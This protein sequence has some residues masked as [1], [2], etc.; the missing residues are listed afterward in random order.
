M[1]TPLNTNIDSLYD[2]VLQQMAAESYFE[3]IALTASAL[4]RERLILGANRENYRGGPSDLNDGYRGYTR[5]TSAQ[6][7]EFLRKF[8]IVHQWSDDPTPTGSRPAVEGRPDRPQ[9]GDEILANTGLSATLIRDLRTGSYTLSIRSTEYRAWSEGGDRER[10][11]FGADLELV[12]NGFS[13]AQLNALQRYYQWLKSQPLL[14]IGATL[15][16]T[17]YSLGGHLA[18]VFTEMHRGDTDIRFGQ[19]V[20][21]NGAGRGAWNGAA[22][23]ISDMVAYHH[24]V[25]N[26]PGLAPDPS[27]E[28]GVTTAVREVALARAGSS[29]TGSA[30]M[31]ISTPWRHRSGP[32]EDEI[33]WAPQSGLTAACAHRSRP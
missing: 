22:G 21:F 23:S 17:G 13:L 24:A 14:P 20:T 10:D 11:G 4:V 28:P 2:Y 29:R 26:D 1:P 32:L 6:A 25:L 27:R 30:S 18:T 9:L 19:T 15:D 12:A 31:S 5:M 16:V 3:G 8:E 7:D 33:R